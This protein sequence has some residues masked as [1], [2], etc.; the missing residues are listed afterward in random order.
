MKDNLNTREMDKFIIAFVVLA[1]NVHCSAQKCMIG[2]G[3]KRL[4]MGERLV[5][6][7]SVVYGRTVQHL[8]RVH[9]AFGQTT[10]VIDAIFEIYC[11]IKSGG[12]IFEKEIR[13]EGISPRDGCSGSKGNMQIGQEAFI[14]L[15]P[16]SEGNFEFDEV[17]PTLSAVFAA[18]RTNFQE[19]SSFCGLQAWE[20]PVN[21]TINKCPVCGVADF[22][23]AVTDLDESENTLTCIVNGELV[24]NTL[25][26]IT[27]CDFLLSENTN[28]EDN[29][30]PSTFANTCTR[31][32]V[33]YDKV[34]CVCASNTEAGGG[35]ADVS[36]GNQRWA[37]FSTVLSLVLVSTSV[38]HYA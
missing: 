16:T 37:S 9:K 26:N 6:A 31:L 4:S 5:S 3:W 14:A 25:D 34:N 15:K 18:T 33:T 12:E 11:V 36:G 27:A 10:S 20:S 30:I 7:H 24:S 29:C 17:M 22:T 13:I 23:S 35:F 32:L 2:A 19:I 8:S 38:R 1:F 21:A 28:P